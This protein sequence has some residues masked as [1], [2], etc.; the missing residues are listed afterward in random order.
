MV[1][2]GAGG[3][4]QVDSGLFAGLAGGDFLE[5]S[6]VVCGLGF[7]HEIGGGAAFGKLGFLSAKGFGGFRKRFAAVFDARL[8]GA[9][10]VEG[11]DD[12]FG[13]VGF[14]SAGGDSG[15]LDGGTGTRDVP[16]GFVVSEG[17]GELEAGDPFVAVE[18]GEAVPRGRNGGC[19]ASVAVAGDEVEFWF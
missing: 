4:L 3:G 2:E 5:R 7:E 13:D 10:G 19:R 14:D 6:H 11:E 17:E 9:K 18:V 8:S 1:E 16:F 12:F 15:L